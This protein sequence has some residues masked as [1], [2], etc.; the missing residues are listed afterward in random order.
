MTH[1][2]PRDPPDEELCEYRPH[3]AGIELL[4]EYLENIANEDLCAWASVIS[5]EGMDLV[6]ELTIDAL[7]YWDKGDYYA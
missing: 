4:L 5:D 3:D 2:G 1:A 7:Y 6:D